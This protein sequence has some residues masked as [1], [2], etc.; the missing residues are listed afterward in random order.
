MIYLVNGFDTEGKELTRDF[1][2]RLVREGKA[3]LYTDELGLVQDFN[4]KGGFP[5]GSRLAFV[6]TP[7]KGYVEELKD[8][9][10]GLVK[11]LGEG[12]DYVDVAYVSKQNRLSLWNIYTDGSAGDLI[13]CTLSGVGVGLNG[14]ITMD[15][16][17]SLY[18]DK[19]DNVE[20]LR[21][22]DYETLAIALEDIDRAISEK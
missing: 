19:Y 13:C 18:G 6:E 22:D 9:I 16:V 1:L 14:E 17:D 3:T 5:A 10:I 2:D 7:V 4:G 8:K 12:N 15:L 21:T 11:K 20:P